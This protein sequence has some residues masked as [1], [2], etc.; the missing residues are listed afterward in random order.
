[1]TVHGCMTFPCPV[2]N[3]SVSTTISTSWHLP[4]EERCLTFAE[5]IA[6]ARRA[7]LGSSVRPR[8]YRDGNEWVVSYDQVPV[9]WNYEPWTTNPFRTVYS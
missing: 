5:A 6:R 1:M 7:F 9:A 8:V 3:G 4:V 2:C